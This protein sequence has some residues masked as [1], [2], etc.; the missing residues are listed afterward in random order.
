MNLGTWKMWQ[1]ARNNFPIKFF[2]DA[3]TEAKYGDFP[4]GSWNFWHIKLETSPI[5]RFPKNQLL[6]DGIKLNFPCS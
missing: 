4:P 2:I 3:L 5:P 1:W 6:V